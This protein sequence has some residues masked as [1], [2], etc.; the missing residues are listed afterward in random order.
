LD[1][2]QCACATNHLR[3]GDGSRSR[4]T[5]GLDSND[6]VVEVL[7]G[8]AVLGPGVEVVGSGDGTGSTLVLTD[9]PVL[10]EGGGTSDGGLVGASVGA[11]SVD[12]AVRGDRAELGHAAGA[13]V[14]GAVALNDVVLGLRV[15]NPTVNGEVRAAVAG[16]VGAGVLDGP[17][18]S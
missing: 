13:R 4:A 17:A 1:S 7:V 2:F 9:R 5:E 15:V 12:G 16:R 14:E 10:G 6:L 18:K 3:D 8:E 11:E